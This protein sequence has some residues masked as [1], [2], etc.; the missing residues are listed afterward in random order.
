MK[1]K[2]K[3]TA[4]LA[5]LSLLCTTLPAMSASALWHYGNVP[6][7]EFEEKMQRLDDKGMIGITDVDY[8]VYVQHIS[9]DVIEDPTYSGTD[10]TEHVCRHVEADNVYVI[11]PR[12]TML[13][14]E[15]IKDADAQQA[16]QIVQKYFPNCEA[17][18]LW[19]NEFTHINA[20]D[21]YVDDNTLRT[22]ENAN[23]LMHELAE[24]GLISKFYSWGQTAYYQQYEYG[25]TGSVAQEKPLL[26]TYAPPFTEM[27]YDWEIHGFNKEKVTQ[28]LE[29]NEIDCTVQEVVDTNGW[30]TYKGEKKNV[31]YYQV[32]PNGEMSFVDQFALGADLYD[33][34]GYR[35]TWMCCEYDSAEEISGDNALDAQGDLNIDGKV[36]VSDAILL[37]RITAEDTTVSLPNAGKPKTDVNGDQNINSADVTALLRIVAKCR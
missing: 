12:T 6:I 1:K 2:M 36:S 26:L 30:Y 32:V 10:I 17:C 34:F 3:L 33:K 27:L 35:I 28:Y 31:T 15:L 8:E 16:A 11:I 18:P 24:A 13:R 23:Q 4:I 14:Y 25:Y 9:R 29:E 20:Y 37:A 7:D 5:S 22:N 19:T 21:V